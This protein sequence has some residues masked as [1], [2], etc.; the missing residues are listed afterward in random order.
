MKAKWK[1]LKDNYRREL[2]KLKQCKSGDAG[3]SIKTTTWPFFE[4]MYFLK[5][6]LEPTKTSCNLAVGRTDAEH[7]DDEDNSII[8]QDLT[9]LDDELNV[10]DNGL[11]TP[12]TVSRPTSSASSSNQS[13]KRKETT[14]NVVARKM[15]QLEEEKVS[16]LKKETKEKSED[17]HF[18]M[19]L[20]P[21]LEAMDPLQKLRVRNKLTDVIIDAK[22]SNVIHQR[23]TNISTERLTSFNCDQENPGTHHNNTL[24]SADYSY[25][26][27]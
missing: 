26:N 27:N 5:H 2:R 12:A 15:L 11:E 7:E 1:N 22:T 19:S 24:Y 20:L 4:L 8:D 25:L 23:T 13:R 10:G 21:H 6:E 17:Y 3:G 14:P 9:Q 16:L 18:L